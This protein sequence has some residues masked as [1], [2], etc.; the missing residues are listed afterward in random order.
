MSNIPD[1]H[2]MED[3]QNLQALVMEDIGGEQTRH[4]AEYFQTAADKSQEMQLHSTDFEQKEFARL[5][6][7]A[8]LAARHIVLVA[9]EKIHGTTLAV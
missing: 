1:I 9:W 4:L 7:E 2:V 5:L 8:Y 6:H 3:F